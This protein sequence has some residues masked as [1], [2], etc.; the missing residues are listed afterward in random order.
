MTNEE[1]KDNWIGKTVKIDGRKYEVVD[2]DKDQVQVIE[3]GKYSA[4]WVLKSEVSL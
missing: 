4:K 2:H 1:I 3:F